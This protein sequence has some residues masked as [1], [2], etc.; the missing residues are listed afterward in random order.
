MSINVTRYIAPAE[1]VPQTAART[2]TCAKY[3]FWQLR[4]QQLPNG[5]TAVLKDKDC[6][7]RCGPVVYGVNG[8]RVEVDVLLHGFPTGVTMPY[9]PQTRSTPPLSPEQQLQ[10]AAAVAAVG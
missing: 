8:L 2:A 4:V 10:L 9:P 1:I 3:W 5:A 7:L 6:D